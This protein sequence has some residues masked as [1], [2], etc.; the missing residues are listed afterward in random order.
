MDKMV[1]RVAYY[2]KKANQYSTASIGAVKGKNPKPKANRFKRLM[3]LK[4]SIKRA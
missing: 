3:L 1:K 4:Q 2:M